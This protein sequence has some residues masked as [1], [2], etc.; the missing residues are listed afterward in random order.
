MQYT[1]RNLRIELKQALDLVDKGE[2][3]VITRKGK[4]YH[5]SIIRDEDFVM[6]ILKDHGKRLARLED[7]KVEPTYVPFE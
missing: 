7:V 6:D 3:V 2:T 1:A 4:K 5:L